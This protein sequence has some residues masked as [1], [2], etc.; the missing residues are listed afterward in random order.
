MYQ[1]VTKFASQTKEI[2]YLSLGAE[3]KTLYRWYFKASNDLNLMTNYLV[4]TGDDYDADLTLLA[5]TIIDKHIETIVCFYEESY[6]LAKSIKKLDL[7]I[8]NVIFDP[9]LITN[10]LTSNQAIKINFNLIIEQAMVIINSKITSNE[11][12]V[13]PVKIID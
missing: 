1:L 9:N 5:N 6:F 3:W 7:K 4:L 8:I 2:L 10:Y 12:H 13:I 11:Q